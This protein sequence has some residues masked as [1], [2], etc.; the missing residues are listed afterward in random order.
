MGNRRQHGATL[1]RRIEDGKLWL[2]EDRI[3]DGIANELVANSVPKDNIVPG[4]Q[5]P[6]VRSAAEMAA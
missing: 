2:E 4:F 3:E 5:P 1:Y 6:S